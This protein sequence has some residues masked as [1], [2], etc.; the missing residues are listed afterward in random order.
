MIFVFSSPPFGGKVGIGINIS[1]LTLYNVNVPRF[2]TCGYVY[3]V[4]FI[5]SFYSTLSVLSN[6]IAACEMANF[7]NAKNYS[8]KLF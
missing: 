2:E 3:F 8:R 7:E 1:N 5:Y 6:Y 4:R